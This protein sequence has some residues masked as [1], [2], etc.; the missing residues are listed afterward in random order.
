MAFRVAILPPA[1]NNSPLA[2]K[3]YGDT[4]ETA[5]TELVGGGAPAEIAG[6][7]LAYLEERIRLDLAHKRRNAAQVA[8]NNAAIA[9]IAAAEASVE[10]DLA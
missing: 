9:A 1:P 8:A 10:T 4:A 2:I 5:I 3:E 7:L 6:N